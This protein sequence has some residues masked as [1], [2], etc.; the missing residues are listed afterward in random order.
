MLVLY[1]TWPPDEEY[2][3]V[4]VSY[5]GAAGDAGAEIFIIAGKDKHDLGTFR[6]GDRQRLRLIPGRAVVPFR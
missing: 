6:V 4:V 1:V 2:I 3:N 5:Q